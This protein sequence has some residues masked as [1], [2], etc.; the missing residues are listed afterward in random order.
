MLESCPAPGRLLQHKQM[1][2][3]AYTSQDAYARLDTMR[4]E[5][6]GCAKT[7]MGESAE[8]CTSK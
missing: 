7:I 2:S 4:K 5:N 8:L 3:L 6:A 1:V